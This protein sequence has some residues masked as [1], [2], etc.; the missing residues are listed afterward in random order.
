VTGFRVS[1]PGEAL[2]TAMI[3]IAEHKLDKQGLAGLL[4]RLA[5]GVD[6]E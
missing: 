6:E 4:R 2:Y 1:D 5:H 3:D